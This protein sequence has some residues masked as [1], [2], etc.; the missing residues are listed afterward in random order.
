VTDNITALTQSFTSN[1]VETYTYVVF[2]CS[3]ANEC[4]APS[5]PVSIRI[6]CVGPSCNARATFPSTLTYVHTDQLGSPVAES[7]V[8]G[9]ITARFRYEPYGQSLESTPAQGPSYT[10]HVYDAASGLI[11]MQQRYYDPVIGRFLSTDPDPV[12]ELG[13]NFNRYNYAGNNPYKYVDPDGRCVEDLCVGEAILIVTALTSVA[14]ATNNAFENI[15]RDAQ[16]NQAKAQTAAAQQAANEAESGEENPDFTDTEG[17]K[18]PDRANP[19]ETIRGGTKS[20][21]YDENGWP[22]TDREAGHP[23]EK[24]CGSEEHCHDWTN[25]SDGT[26][27]KHDDRGP[28]RP[29]EPGDP[30]SPRGP[31]VPPPKK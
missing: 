8:S 1:Q 17:N 24:G 5:T 3:A 14:I 9:T 29:P 26:R 4:S 28:P 7:D 2:A 20:R 16:Q 15:K 10:G 19:G 13:L 31:N 18:V 6:D 22:L 21:K 23:D 11:Y 12:G 25:P 27:P 30:P